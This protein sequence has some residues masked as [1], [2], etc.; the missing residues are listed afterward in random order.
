VRHF[1]TPRSVY[2]PRE[3]AKNTAPTATPRQ[4]FHEFRSDDV[5]RWVRIEDRVSEMYDVVALSGL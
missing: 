5:A 4:N 3:T 1:T 2:L